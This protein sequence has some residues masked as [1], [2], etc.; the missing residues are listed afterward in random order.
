MPGNGQLNSLSEK[1]HTGRG[2][3]SSGST[4][5]WL[6]AEQAHTKNFSL[7]RPKAQLHGPSLLSSAGV[8]SAE[9]EVI[10]TLHHKAETG[11]RMLRVNQEQMQQEME[12]LQNTLHLREYELNELRVSQTTLTRQTDLLYPLSM[13][14][15][16]PPLS[17]DQNPAA[18]A[19]VA[20]VRHRTVR[21]CT[22]PQLLRFIV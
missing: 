13:H 7:M 15:P 17:M 3:W 21:T 20:S 14:T 6:S 2:N 12:Q 22:P 5:S 1:S 9:S 16:L 4:A 10:A 11:L 19:G 8:M 18:S